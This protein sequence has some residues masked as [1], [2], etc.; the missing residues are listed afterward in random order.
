MRLR[1]LLPTEVL[2]EAPVEKVVAE[3]ANGFFCLLPR[4][5]DFVAALV[6]G[7]L[8]YVPTDGP[9]TFVA[10]DSGTLVKC[11]DDVLVSVHNAIMGT[12]LT[13]LE[14]GVVKSFRASQAEGDKAR[15]ALARLEAGAMR[16]FLEMERRSHD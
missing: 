3:A 15:A 2:I 8:S 6:P 1:V 10:V 14:S 7:V 9:E 4:H 13:R 11:G 16:R 5:I 12:E